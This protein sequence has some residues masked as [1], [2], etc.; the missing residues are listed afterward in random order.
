MKRKTISIILIIIIG[1]IGL[2]F[3][4]N[5]MAKPRYGNN[6][7]NPYDLKIDSIGQVSDDQFCNYNSSKIKL[8]LKNAKAIGIG[9]NDLIYVSGDNK[10]QIFNPDG[11][12]NSEFSTSK[13]ASSIIIS[14]SNEIYL[15]LKDHIE[16]YDSSYNLISK[17]ESLGENAYI[18]SIA[19]QKNKVYLAE[20]ETE[21]VYVYNNNGVL[22]DIIGDSVPANDI[23]RFVLPS[24]YFDL[25]IDTEGFLWVANTGKH[26]LIS[27]NSSGKL[28]SYWGKSSVELD[29][30]C[31][32]C[33]P[34]HFSITESGSFITS[35]KGIVRVK[36]YDSAG[37]FVCAVAGPEHFK[38]NSEGLDI[39]IDSKQNIYVLEPMAQVIHIFKEN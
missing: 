21:L 31:G 39:A 38:K 30:F 20:A 23:L 5:Y 14:K 24:Y 37:Q 2:Y 13:T 18:M 34:T 8:N 9:Y 33:N 11:T 4:G 36:K 26:K 16:K 25:T 3:L 17:W 22:E 28:R 35:E 12:F 10:I 6:Y 19:L 7:T 32:C 1:I 15:G 27:F 29:G